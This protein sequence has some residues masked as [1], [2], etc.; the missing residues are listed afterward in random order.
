M[1]LPKP[2]F[3]TFTSSMAMGFMGILPGS[4]QAHSVS[5]SEEQCHC[6]YLRGAMSLHL[7]SA[8]LI[9]KLIGSTLWRD[10]IGEVVWVLGV[11]SVA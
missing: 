3:I 8:A 10:L 11:T 2:R 6:L 5:I 7:T 9:T 1:L 4:A